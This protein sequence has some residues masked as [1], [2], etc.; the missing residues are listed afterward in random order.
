MEKEEKPVNRLR[1]RFK[2]EGKCLPLRVGMDALLPEDH[3]L[4][5]GINAQPGDRL[6]PNSRPPG[7]ETFLRKLRQRQDEVAETGLRQIEE[8]QVDCE[9]L[10]GIEAKFV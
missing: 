4:R 9:G 2:A 5:C 3:L 7:A 8:M 6:Q 10:T 1:M